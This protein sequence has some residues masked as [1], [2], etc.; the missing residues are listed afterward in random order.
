MEKSVRGGVVETGFVNGRFKRSGGV[1]GGCLIDGCLIDGCII[2]KLVTNRIV[3]ERAKEG[4]MTNVDDLL[5][6]WKMGRSGVG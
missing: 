4:Q 6:E 5:K 1:T 3:K 2:G